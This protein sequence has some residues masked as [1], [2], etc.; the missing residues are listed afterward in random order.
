M[1]S[2]VKT[3][4]KTECGIVC[5]PEQVLLYACGRAHLK[6]K[7][8]INRHLFET[9]KAGFQKI[10]DW[11]LRP[12]LDSLRVKVCQMSWSGVACS[13]HSSISCS[14]DTCTRKK[15]DMDTILFQKGIL[16]PS[17]IDSQTRFR[18]YNSQRLVGMPARLGCALNLVSAVLVKSFA[19]VKLTVIGPAP[20]LKMHL[21]STSSKARRTRR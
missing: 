18:K 19:E 17:T 21:H 2:G 14:Y 6:I 1:L 10:S 7:I 13:R 3:T 4:Q 12:R 15:E 9:K 5:N 16:L 8:R 11:G 20:S